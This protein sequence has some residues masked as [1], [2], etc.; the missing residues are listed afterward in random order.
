NE[1]ASFMV[2]WHTHCSM[3]SNSGCATEVRSSSP[4]S[5]DQQIRVS[6]VRPRGRAEGTRRGDAEKRR[7]PPARRIVARRVLVAELG[8]WQQP[9]PE[10]WVIR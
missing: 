2:R 3:A 4:K 6:E 10:M 9:L 5:D 1:P 7:P 8:E